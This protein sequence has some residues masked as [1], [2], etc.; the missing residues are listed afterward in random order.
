VED[1]RSGLPSDAPALTAI[2]KAAKR[3]WGYPE[4]WMEAWSSALTITPELVATSCVLVA[5]TARG[6]VGFAVLVDRLT[7]WALDH[8]WILPAHQGHGL[9]RRLFDAAVD[10]VRASRP[11]IVI[12]EAEPFAEGFYQRCGA[13]R[14]G[15]VSAPVLGH[16]RELPVLEIVISAP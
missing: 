4:A 5:E 14:T 2:A 8:L 6:P 7:H 13:K 1:I 9:G 15:S 12:I 16:P 10:H 11:G 3:N